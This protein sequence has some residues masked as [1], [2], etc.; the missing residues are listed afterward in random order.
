MIRGNYINSLENKG[1]LERTLGI[2]RN[3]AIKIL[4][5]NIINIQ[6]YIIIIKGNGEKSLQNKKMDMIFEAKY[7]YHNND[8]NKLY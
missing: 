4:E 2:N 3:N 1:N 8:Q 5:K 6:E 7:K